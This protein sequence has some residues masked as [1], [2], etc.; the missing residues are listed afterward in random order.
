[1]INEIVPVKDVTKSLGSSL[2]FDNIYNLNELPN[3]K[4]IALLNQSQ[5]S[6]SNIL[7]YF[8]WYNQIR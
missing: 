5:L 4:K 8:P 7:Q 1:M 3:L 6:A 2:K